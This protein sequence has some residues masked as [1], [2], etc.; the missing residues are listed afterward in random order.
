MSK[1]NDILKFG[2]KILSGTNIPTVPTSEYKSDGTWNN[3][4][5]YDGQLAVNKDNGKLYLRS[6][7]SIIDLTNTILTANTASASSSNVGS[8]RYRT[9]GNNSY[10]DICMQIGASTYSWVNIIHYNW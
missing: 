6:G 2:W 9:S 3:T 4:D 5:L 7:S 1:I 8:L 10:V